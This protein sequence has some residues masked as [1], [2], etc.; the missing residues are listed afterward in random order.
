MDHIPVT[1]STGNLLNFIKSLY[2][3]NNE[4]SI[5]E[6][7]NSADNRPAFE[8]LVSSVDWDPNE[9]ITIA[10]KEILINLLLYEETIVSR[11]KTMR[12][13]AMREGLKVMELA[14]FLY[15]CNKTVVFRGPSC[16]KCSNVC[17]AN[18]L[19]HK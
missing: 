8:Q 1:S 14:P 5:K 17:K 19:E 6:L 13:E 9:P 12:V 18:K 7:F 11:G 10:N 16:L 15:E 4:Q 3:C 2:N